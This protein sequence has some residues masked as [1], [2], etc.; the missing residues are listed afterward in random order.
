MP[1]KKKSKIDNPVKRVTWGTQE[2]EK[3]TKKN[4]TQ[5]VLDNTSTIRKQCLP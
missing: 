2:E 3:K 1:K 5:Y 4:I